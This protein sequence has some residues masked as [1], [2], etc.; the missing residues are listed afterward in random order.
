MMYFM[1]FHVVDFICNHLYVFISQKLYT[2]NVLTFWQICITKNRVAFVTKSS[3]LQFQT[4]L[5]DDRHKNKIRMA[6][7]SVFRVS[8]SGETV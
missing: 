5:T 8:D 1:Y 6:Y 4:R 2:E 3:C 7:S